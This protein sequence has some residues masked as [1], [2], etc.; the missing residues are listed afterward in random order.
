MLNS[1]LNLLDNVSC[2]I[3][4]N[5]DE[6]LSEY[7]QDNLNRLSRLLGFTGS[8]G[9]A[10]FYLNQDKMQK[11]FL[12]DSRYTLQAKDELKDFEIYDIQ[13]KSLTQLLQEACIKNIIINTKICSLAFCQ[14]L[15]DL[16][17]HILHNTID[18]ELLKIDYS[19]ISGEA[20]IFD[21]EELIFGVAKEQK[22]KLLAKYINDKK[23][24]A[25][26]LSDPIDVNY[27]LNIRGKDFGSVPIK[28]CFA[29]VKSNCDYMLFENNDLYNFSF[30]LKTSDRLI[31]SNS[32]SQYCFDLLDKLCNVI[33]VADRFV[34]FMRA[35]KNKTEIENLTKICL[36]D[37]KVLNKFIKTWIIDNKNIGQESEI[38]L[39]KQLFKMRSSQSNFVCNSFD[40]ISAFG[41]NGAIVHYKPNKVSDVKIKGDGLYLLDS[42]GH[43]FYGTTDVTRTVLVGKA[44]KEW[45]TNFTLVLKGHIAIASLVFPDGL[46]GSD[47]DILA[48]QNLWSQGLDYGHGT[49]HGV[50]YL[51]SVHEGPCGISRYNRTAFK[52][53]MVVSNEPGFYKQREYGIRIE[54]L[55]LVQKSQ[56]YQ[57]FLEFKTLTFVALDERL[58]DKSMLTSQELDWFSNYQELSFVL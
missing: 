30:F 5:G 14:K 13:N 1:I 7:P 34:E 53:G 26:F 3:L 40:T 19:N 57:N 49:G 39:S 54:N 29:I 17:L 18:E 35:V 55:L 32:A 48:R 36:Q 23:C 56:K 41:S 37:S 9:M 16:D 8:N 47:I 2:F 12:T 10:I 15:K 28:A 24:D 46:S 27:I 42:G 25:I 21:K 51:L 44:K 50:G 45:V 58:V 38:S 43:Y 52:E 31:V 11:I 33:L 20:I 4:K 22:L 6:F